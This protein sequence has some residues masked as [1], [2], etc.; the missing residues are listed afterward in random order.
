MII[1]AV[2]GL[3]GI[4]ISIIST[5]AQLALGFIEFNHGLLAFMTI[6]WTLFLFM[7]AIVKIY[8]KIH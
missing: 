4:T 5:L 2:I 8:N 7:F 3:I 1:L 6:Q